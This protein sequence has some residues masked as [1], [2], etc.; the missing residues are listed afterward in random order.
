M[1][2]G[3]FDRNATSPSAL[4]P[5]LVRSL[6]ESLVA[7]VIFWP[8]ISL[9]LLGPLSQLSGGEGEEAT[10]GFSWRRCHQDGHL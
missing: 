4:Q 2:K 3:G 6:A 8:L 9:F 7:H 5:R 1:N 10:A